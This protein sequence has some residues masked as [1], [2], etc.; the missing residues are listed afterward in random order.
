M[1]SFMHQRALEPGATNNSQKGMLFYETIPRGDT[2]RLVKNLSS[3]LGQINFFG[4]HKSR[5]PVVFQLIDPLI[6]DFL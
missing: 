6:L 3:G 5:F 2:R 4:I 1:K